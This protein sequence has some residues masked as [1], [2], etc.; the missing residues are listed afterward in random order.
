M[1]SFQ[2][3]YWKNFASTHPVPILDASYFSYLNVRRAEQ[4]ANF[5]H[6]EN[7]VTEISFLWNLLCLSLAFDMHPTSTAF[8]INAKFGNSTDAGILE[9]INWRLRCV[10]S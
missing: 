5:S 8:G 2:L 7:R 3:F 4:A 6:L 10:V 9:Y 1:E